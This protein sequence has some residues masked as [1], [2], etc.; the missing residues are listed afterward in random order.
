[1]N[2]PSDPGSYVL[3]LRADSCA[4]L[5]VGAL[6]ELRLEPGFYLYVGSALGPGGLGARLRHHAGSRAR[7]HWHID[8]LR[9]RAAIHEIWWSI[10]PQRLEHEWARALA[11][12]RRL[13]VPLPGFGSSD[14]NC[15]AHLFFSAAEPSRAALRR[16]SGAVL[17]FCTYAGGVTP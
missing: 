8:Y 15:P 11:R 12:S 14:C 5:E 13:R 7:P 1:M 2:L 3:V 9:A 16:T 10:G 17:E 6:G 4:E